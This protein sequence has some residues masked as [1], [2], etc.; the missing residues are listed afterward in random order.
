MSANWIKRP[1]SQ[2]LER[3]KNLKFVPTMQYSNWELWT[4]SWQS[5]Q[6][7]TCSKNQNIIISAKHRKLQSIQNWKLSTLF[8]VLKIRSLLS[9]VRS[10]LLPYVLPYMRSV[11][12]LPQLCGLKL[13]ISWCSASTLGGI[14]CEMHL[15][16]LPRCDW[17][18]HRKR[19]PNAATLCKSLVA[20]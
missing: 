9:N 15:R 6:S 20:Q 7:K 11:L 18:C 17:V 4:I 3:N 16:L 14:V 19:P 8:A 12:P 13:S 1:A 10:I 2:V 5:E